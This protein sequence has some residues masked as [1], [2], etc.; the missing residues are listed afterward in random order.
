MSGK[1]PHDFRWFPT[2]AVLS[3]VKIHCA[4]SNKPPDVGPHPPAMNDQDF[5]QMS[6]KSVLDLLDKKT[7]RRRFLREGGIAALAAGVATA[8]KPAADKA[9]AVAQQGTAAAGATRGPTGAHHTA[10][11]APATAPPQ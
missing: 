8:C 3:F 11:G 9:P 4:T 2:E 10:G 7:S 1:P 5:S 6:D